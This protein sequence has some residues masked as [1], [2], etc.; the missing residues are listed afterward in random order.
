MSTDEFT[1]LFK[2]MTKRFDKIE[3]T[4][5]Q[6]A[7]KV[8][9]NRTLDMLDSVIRR[10]EISDQERLVMGHQTERME[11]WSRELAGKIGH[12]LSA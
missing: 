10:Q 12:K 7:D 11:R 8:D 4:L 3:K 1:K 6:K 9:L 5:E 2:Y